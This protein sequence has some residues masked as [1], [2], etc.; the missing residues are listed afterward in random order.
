MYI[1]KRC[2][3]DFGESQQQHKSLITLS[4][5]CGTHQASVSMDDVDGRGGGGGFNLKN[6]RRRFGV[7]LCSRPSVA[8]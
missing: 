6:I 5:M 2:A 7:Q 4:G 8:H 3:M 1:N